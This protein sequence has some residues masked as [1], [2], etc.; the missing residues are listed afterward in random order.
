MPTQLSVVEKQAMELPREE[1][2]KLADRLLSSLIEEENVDDAWMLEVERRIIEIE[3]GR[4]PLGSLNY[5]ISRAR[6][7]VK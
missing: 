6:S 1:R 7:I 4:M 2:A 3:A 5:T